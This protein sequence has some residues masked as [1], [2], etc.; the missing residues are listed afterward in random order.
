MS[1][2]EMNS[3][4]F[5]RGE[6]PSDE[7]LAQIMKEAAE[8]ANARFEDASKKYFKELREGIK[9]QEVKWSDRINKIK[10]GTREP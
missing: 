1:E 6:D 5:G 3:Y 10:N 8:D 9:E 7:M 2:A 4:R